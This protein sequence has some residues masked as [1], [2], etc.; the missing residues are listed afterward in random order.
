MNDDGSPLG[1]AV[2]SRKVKLDGAE[3]THA[4]RVVRR[5][6]EGVWLF[7]PAGTEVV[8]PDGPLPAQPA[9]GVQFFPAQAL[10]ES[11]GWFVAWCWSAAPEPPADHW[12]SPWISVDVAAARDELFSFLDLELDLWCSAD[13]AGIVDADELDDAEAAD[14]VD[15]ATAAVARHAADELYRALRSGYHTAFDGL[16]WRLLA[17]IRGRPADEP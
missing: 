3:K 8:G 1:R 6:P 11:G 10:P 12:T 16:G 14:L 7:S 17:E 9:D 5:G 15:A 13:D 4:S 2:R